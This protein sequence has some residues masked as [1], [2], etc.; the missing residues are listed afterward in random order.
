MLKTKLRFLP[1]FDL[2]M[3]VARLNLSQKF[4]WLNLVFNTC[5]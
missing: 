1:E 5:Q 3:L 2:I 4:I